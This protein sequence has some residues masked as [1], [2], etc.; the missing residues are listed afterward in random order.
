MSGT[1]T[2][3]IDD[4]NH[5]QN[6]FN[7]RNCVFIAQRTDGKSVAAITIAVAKDDIT[8]C[9]ANGQAIIAIVDYVVLE[10]DIRSP[11]RETYQAGLI[12]S[13]LPGAIEWAH[14]R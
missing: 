3:V 7:I 4:A 2:S 5:I 14:R 1:P 13:I 8:C 9:I 6:I 10:Q 11:C 12:K